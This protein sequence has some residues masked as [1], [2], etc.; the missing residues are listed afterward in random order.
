MLLLAAVPMAAAGG[1]SAGPVIVTFNLETDDDALAVRSFPSDLPAT[2]FVTG[3]FAERHEALVRRLAANNTLGSLSYS[4]PDLTTLDPG[5]LHRELQ[6]G[7][8]VLEKI[9]GSPI[10]WFRA[11]F[12][13][14][15][16]A[17]VRAA[18]KVGFRYDS[19]DQERWSRQLSMLELPLSNE[20]GSERLASDYDLFERA[21]MTE[22]QA[23]A[24]LQRRFDERAAR[25]RPLVVMFRPRLLAQRQS[26]LPDF[27]D[28]VRQRGGELMTA[29]QYVDRVLDAAPSR[30]GVWVDFS[31]GSHDIP[32][33]VEDVVAAGMT[34]V[35]VQAKDPEGNRYYANP[36]DG[37]PVRSDVFSSAVAALKARGI[38]VHAWLV[39]CR[40]PHVAQAHPDLAMTGID[41]TASKDW[42]SPAN[43]RARAAILRSVGDI[44]ERYPVD[45]IH[46]DYLRY[47]DF[48][49]DFSAA[50][51]A[52]F[53]QSQAIDE[54]PLREMFD[55]YY[56]AWTRWRS[57]HIRQV[58]EDVADLVRARRGRDVEMSAALYADAATSYRVME[59]TGQDYAA[60]A[61]HLDT[62]IP[63]A[64]VQEQKRT[65]DWIE[66][67]ALATRYRTGNREVLAGLEAFQRP[68]QI[69][70]T[71]EL[72]G[73]TVAAA[74]RGYDG[75]V[76]YA[77]SYL[78]GR[79]KSGFNL[80]EGSLA[81]LP[82]LATGRERPRGRAT[83]AQRFWLVYPVLGA[84]F[85]TAAY[86]ASRGRARRL[87]AQR[88][89]RER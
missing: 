69:S 29:Q 66:K 89:S 70:Y 27:L 22:A 55:R 86:L 8:L 44:L 24:W 1:G 23:L 5:A 63:M 21:G 18:V 20:D 49:H 46:L 39:A 28:L 75:R 50:N 67:V 58:A 4:H 6:L 34:D 12:L 25:R 74:Q 65:I 56:N 10:E 83:A 85:L 48:D 35:F 3:A 13:S 11:P 53:R 30:S 31:Q 73:Q 54:M 51:V 41:G 38:R 43:I 42:L 16:D 47:P 79:G 78:F 64:Y 40:D 19:S 68:G 36:S 2:Y 82:P 17:V 59:K 60:L 33:L 71:P 80:P 62:V 9:A 14:Y 57:E 61:A 72:F 7:R 77:Y 37:G 45:G 84:I 26:L 88:T 52:A 32:Q 76:F 15:D 87:A 81:Q